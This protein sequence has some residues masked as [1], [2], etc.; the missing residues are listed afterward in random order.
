[1]VRLAWGLAVGVSV[2]VLLGATGSVGLDTVAVLLRLPVRRALV[3]K[4]SVKTCGPE[5][6]TRVPIFAVIVPL[7]PAAVVSV[8]DQP[9][10]RLNDTNVVPAGSASLKTIFCASDGPVLATV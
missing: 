9:L 5:F 2:S 7:A 1:M 10:G 6:A 8:R 4:T 3:L